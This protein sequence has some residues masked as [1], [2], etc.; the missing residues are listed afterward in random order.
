MFET[1]K[2]LFT[3]N[4]GPR[5]DH[6]DLGVSVSRADGS[7]EYVRWDELSEVTVMTTDEG[8]FAEDVFWL[9]VGAFDEDGRPVSGCALPGG[10]VKDALLDRLLALPGFDYAMFCAAMG[11][12]SNAQ[13]TCWRRENGQ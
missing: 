11:S 6:D 10:A 2:R 9:L 5:L 1:I 7:F 12:T 8:P 3:P 13:F 4:P